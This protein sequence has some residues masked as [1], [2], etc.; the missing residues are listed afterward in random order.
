MTD[1][2]TDDGVETGESYKDHRE[3]LDEGLEAA[4]TL[5]EIQAVTGAS[6]S[7]VECLAKFVAE[8]SSHSKYSTADVSE[9]MVRLAR[10]GF[11]ADEL[12]VNAETVLWYSSFTGTSLEIGTKIVADVLTIYDL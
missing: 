10:H 6:D 1:E 7:D 12:E 11:D 5:V 3:E 4:K 8:I 2:T 9:V